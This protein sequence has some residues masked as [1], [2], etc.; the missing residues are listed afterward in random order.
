MNAQKQRRKDL[1]AERRRGAGEHL[2]G[3]HATQK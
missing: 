2:D 3:A 1:E